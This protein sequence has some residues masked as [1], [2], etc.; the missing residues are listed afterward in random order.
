[1]HPRFL[2]RIALFMS[3]WLMVTSV[4]ATIDVH[5]C[6]GEIYSL[7]IN[8]E[9]D[10][11]EGFDAN[12]V[13]DKEESICKSPCCDQFTAYFQ[14]DVESHNDAIA[15]QFSSFSCSVP[16]I[17]VLDITKRKGPIQ[18]CRIHLP[19]DCGDDI[20]TLFSVLRI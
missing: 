13:D 10:K 7:G 19:P 2:K 3:S 16:F 5:F 20:L 17:H 12:S 4:G 9:A 6:R 8:A 18:L 14:S 15:F 11:C 1:M